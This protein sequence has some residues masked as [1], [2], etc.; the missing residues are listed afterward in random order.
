MTES[1]FVEKVRV[2]DLAAYRNHNDKP[3][4]A[5][6]GLLIPYRQKPGFFRL[7]FLHEGIDGSPGEAANTLI[8]GTSNVPCVDTLNFAKV[9][10]I[11]RE[12]ELIQNVSIEGLLDYPLNLSVGGVMQGYLLP[13]AV[14]REMDNFLA[15]K[16]S[17]V[18]EV[19]DD[20][21][22]YYMH[23]RVGF[24]NTILD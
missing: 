9:Q 24:G 17:L 7:Q 18:I 14:M 16:D 13:D 1:K 23:F 11:Y 15:K 12:S 4:T 6:T 21:N 20:S 3:F 19:S 2:Y 22:L 10:S 5:Y 8:L